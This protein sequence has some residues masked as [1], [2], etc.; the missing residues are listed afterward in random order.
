[1]SILNLEHAVMAECAFCRIVTQKIRVHFL[2]SVMCYT[3]ILIFVSVSSQLSVV[4][5]IG[6]GN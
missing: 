3:V 5:C 2:Y 6:L 4:A 1:M